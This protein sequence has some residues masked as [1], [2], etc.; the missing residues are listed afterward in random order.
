MREFDVDN[1]KVFTDSQLITGQVK[2][3]FEA[4]D[5]TMMKYLQNVRNFIQIFKYFEISHISR[6]ENAHADALSRLMTTSFNLLDR[7]FVEYLEQLSIDK[8]DEVHQINDEPS[9]TDLIIQYL[10]DGTLLGDLLKAKRLRWTVSQ[11]VLMNRQLYKISFS[12]SL[13][14]CLRPIEADYAL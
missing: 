12:F 9:R 2:K 5:P 4:R 3:K 13:L 7:M 8:V 6:S 10:T 11:Y 1:L 14:K